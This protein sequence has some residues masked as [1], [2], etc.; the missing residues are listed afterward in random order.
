[1][2]WVNPIIKINNKFKFQLFGRHFENLNHLVYKIPKFDPQNTGLM[3][4]HT[5]NLFLNA[6]GVFLTTQ[7]IRTIRDNFGTEGSIAYYDFIQNV[8]K[9][10]SEKRMATVDHAFEQ[11]NSGGKINIEGLLSRFQPS[12]HPQVRC[13]NKT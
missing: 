5:F 6:A 13:L 7:E 3:S 10:L 12:R 11:L 1:M 8:R 9:D 4:E 2:D